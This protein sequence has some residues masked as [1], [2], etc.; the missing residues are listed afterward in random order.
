MSNKGKR[1]PV[2][3]AQ[4]CQVIALPSGGLKTAIVSQKFLEASIRKQQC[5]QPKRI[6]IAALSQIN[7]IGKLE[8][9]VK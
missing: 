5:S 4:I 6:K 8:S 7:S 3:P 9:V 2:P 1:T